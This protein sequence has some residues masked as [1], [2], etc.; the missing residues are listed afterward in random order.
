VDEFEAEMADCDRTRCTL[1]RCTV[2]PLAK[3]ESVL[4]KI[5]SRLF[6]E[7]QKTD[8]A[9]KV[10]IS[11][12]LVTRITRL[13]YQA[14]AGKVSYQTHQVTT[15]VFP[16]ELAEGSIPWWVWLLAALGGI[17][18]LALIIYCLYKCGFFKRKRPT[19]DSPERQP[20]NRNGYH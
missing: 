11:S 3:D 9:N 1:M 16:S 8:Y 12:K 5:R 19:N 10:K 14:D 15:E 7:T 18:L 2:G 6:T 13:P 17:L 4:F 20:L